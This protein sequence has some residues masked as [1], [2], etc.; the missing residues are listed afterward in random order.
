MRP[1]IGMLSGALQEKRLLGRNVNQFSGN[2][3]IHFEIQRCED[4]NH[5][6]TVAS[7]E[8]LRVR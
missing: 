4:G 5:W 8:K 2:D 7:G 1:D 6:Q 3:R